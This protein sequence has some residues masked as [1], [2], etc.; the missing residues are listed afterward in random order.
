VDKAI[1]TFNMHKKL[2]DEVVLKCKCNRKE[3][4]E[5]LEAIN[6]DMNLIV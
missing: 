2:I 3:A 5:F 1:E 6:Y 4:K